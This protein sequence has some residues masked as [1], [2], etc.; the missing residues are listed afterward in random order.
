MPCIARE[1]TVVSSCPYVPLKPVMGDAVHR[2]Y[3]LRFVRCGM[4]PSM[5]VARPY[6]TVAIYYM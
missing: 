6:R 3:C 4:E 1:R 2:L 5:L